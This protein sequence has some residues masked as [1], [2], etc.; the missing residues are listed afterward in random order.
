[1]YV[2]TN[3]PPDQD[4]LILGILQSMVINPPVPDDEAINAAWQH[5]LAED[6][7]LRYG[8][9]DSPVSMIEFFDFSCSHCADY[10]FDVGRLLAL[11]V[12]PGR[13]R[14]EFV[15][16]DIIGGEFSNTAAQATL[17]ATEQGKGYTAYKSLWLGYFN[18]GPEAAYSRTGT[19]DLLGTDEIGLDVDALNACLDAGT[20]ADLIQSANSRAQEVGV[21]GTPSVL[22]GVNGDTPAFLALPDGQRWTGGVPVSVLRHVLDRVIN[23]GVPLSD[24][25]NDS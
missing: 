9:L 14:I 19:T 15:L 4:E 22:L 2:Q 3:A 11:E 24:A 18:Q 21:N 17:C 12:E 5:S 23:D 13:L 20:Y 7:T 16:L 8:D 10:S 6:R 25:L 1:M